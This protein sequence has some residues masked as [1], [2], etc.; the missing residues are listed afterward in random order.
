MWIERKIESL[1]YQA[2]EQFPALLI[3]GLRQVGKTSLLRKMFPDASYIT[4]DLP[5]NQLAAA[6]NSLEF[7][8][9]FARPVI[10]DEVQYVP[11]LFQGLKVAIDQQ[12]RNSQ[13]ILTGSQNF[14]FMQG[15]SESLSGRCAMLQLYPLSFYEVSN[16]TSISQ[17]EFIFL[18]GYPEL[19][20]SPKNYNLWYSSYVATYLERDV[21]NVLNVTDLREFNLFL[22]SCALRI[23]NLLSY[24]DLA[25]DIG[26]S[27]NTAKKWLSVL[28]TLGAVYL[29]EPYFANRGK[30][31]IKSPK[32]YFT[33]TGLAAFLCGFEHAQ[34]LHNSSMA[35]YFFENY[36][37]N[38]ITKHYSF[39][40]KRLNLYYWQDIH[41][42]EVD[43][44]IEHASGKIIAIECKLTENP[45]IKDCN[46]I[47]KLIDYYGEDRVST[48]YIV[49]NTPTPYQIDK[50]IYATNI[51]EL[52]S[53]LLK[54]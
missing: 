22:R 14:S 34:Q 29:V 19:H 23:S 12:R 36:I 18:G 41:G 20:T 49:C 48:S 5:A 26:I 33:D 52:L 28:T 45:T 31:I 40:G 44:I 51:G 38:E 35:G 7:I 8:Q 43:F 6:S 16:H 2:F 24:T 37:A 10:I 32:I 13:F 42:K 30:R 21:R 11:Q 47:F 27:V 39:Y 9:R 1:V 25:R 46:N 15:V 17:N 53:T 4:L 3:T 50:K 54:Q